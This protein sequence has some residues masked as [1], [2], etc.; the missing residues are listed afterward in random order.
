MIAALALLLLAGATP[1]IQPSV[2]AGPAPQVQTL[3]RMRRPVIPPR[4]ME[5]VDPALHEAVVCAAH[6]EL[7]MEKLSA[8]GEDADSRVILITE[9][10]MS[11]LPDPDGPNP[12]PDDSFTS[13]KETLDGVANETPAIYL[14]GLQDCVISAARGGALD[15]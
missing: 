2:K 14:Q 13:I 9:Y 1:P 3:V 11:R 5:G 12:V 4:A 10:W 8:R 7:L 15:D 6:M